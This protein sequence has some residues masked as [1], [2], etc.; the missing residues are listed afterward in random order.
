MKK[1]FFAG[2]MWTRDE[3]SLFYFTIRIRL[4]L[5]RDW[6]ISNGFIHRETSFFYHYASRRTKVKLDLCKGMRK[7]KKNILL[8]EKNK[9]NSVGELVRKIALWKYIQQQCIGV[10]YNVYPK[11]FIVRIRWHTKIRAKRAAVLC[12]NTATTL[13]NKQMHKFGSNIG[14]RRKISVAIC[15]HSTKMRK[16]SQSFWR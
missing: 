14:R 9:W 10:L 8:L 5:P 3:N 4:Q 7:K 16:C 11:G 1:T 6:C 15:E 12:L 2:L 13:L